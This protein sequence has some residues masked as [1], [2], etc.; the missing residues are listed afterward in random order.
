MPRVFTIGFT[1]SSAEHFFNRLTD[2]GVR[3]VIDVRVHN[4]SQLAGFA[5]SA[6]LGWFLRE[7]RGI[8]YEHASALAP[9]GEMLK[10]YRAAKRDW[11]DYEHRFRRLMAEREIER[12]FRP[13]AF[14]GACLL[15]SEATPHRCHRRLVCEYLNEKWDNALMVR[16]L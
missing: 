5:K 9:T 1:R 10:S 6:D 3:K 2:A 16:H 15:C 11:D 14:E 12:T 4:T 8:G 13:E 7:L